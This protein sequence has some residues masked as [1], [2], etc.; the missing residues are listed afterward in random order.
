MS[1][2]LIQSAHDVV[3]SLISMI[4]ANH[5]RSDPWEGASIRHGALIRG[6]RLIQTLYLEGALRYEA[7]I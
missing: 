4:G 5:V 7:F 3:H 1:R 6:G 2:R